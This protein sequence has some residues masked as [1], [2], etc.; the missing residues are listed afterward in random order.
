LSSLWLN[1][2]V[3]DIL[4]IEYSLLNLTAAVHNSSGIRHL[5]GLVSRHCAKRKWTSFRVVV[6][7]AGWLIGYPPLVYRKI[8]IVAS[9][10]CGV[11][12]GLPEGHDKLRRQQVDRA[13][14][15]ATLA[16][17][18]FMKV[19]PDNRL[20]ADTLEAEWNEKLRDL[21]DANDYYETHRHRESEKL[22]KAQQKEV[23]KLAKDFP[24]LWENPPHTCS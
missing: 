9:Q 11:M 12:A 10:L 21:Q 3:R 13:E 17:R 8:P 18:R 24:R 7:S 2:N 4:W 22:K 19:D 20:V 14:Y 23:H 5:C 1:R 16:R 6:A 15:E